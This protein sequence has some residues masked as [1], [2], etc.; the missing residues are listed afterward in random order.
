MGSLRGAHNCI[1]DLYPVVVEP[2]ETEIQLNDLLA[3]PKKKNGQ[4]NTGLTSADTNLKTPSVSNSAPSLTSNMS[5]HMDGIKALRTA[6]LLSSLPSF[7][8]ANKPPLNQSWGPSTS[9]QSAESSGP[10]SRSFMRKFHTAHLA[11]A[12]NSDTATA[13]RPGQH[14]SPVIDRLWKIRNAMEAPA[15][16]VDYAKPPQK[17]LIVKKPEDSMLSLEYPF[18]QDLALREKYRN[19]WDSMRVGRLL[20]DLDAIAGSVAFQHCSDNDPETRPLLLVT[21][22]VDRI[23]LARHI[24]MDADLAVTGKVTWVGRSSMEIQI[25]LDQPNASAEQPDSRPPLVANF[26]FVARDITTNK[27]AAINPLAPDTAEEKALFAEG[28]ARDAARKVRRKSGAGKDEALTKEQRDRMEAFL[29]AGRTMLELPA[30]ADRNSMLI[31]DTRLENAFLCQPQ[32]R[33]MH[34]RIFG[35]FLMRRAF[36]LAF[37]T[38]YVFCGT[39]PAF[40]E[41]HDIT[42][43]RPVDVGDL[44]RFKSCVLYTEQ[45][46]LVRPLIHVE[47][48]AYVTKPELRTSQVSNTFYFTFTVH[49]D[50]LK[51]HAT[52]VRRV[53][54]S[55]EEEAKRYMSRFDADHS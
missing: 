15:P 50:D 46:D 18:S 54:P 26:T 49:P 43:Q 14:H 40:L 52:V 41:M 13:T 45:S 25:R 19:P 53:L 5:P 9:S 24:R 21:A 39:R 10:S 1:W 42:F 47:V 11:P 35:G 29:A 38:C 22:S 33:N 8:D 48:V 51:S 28:E 27:A 6:F 55:T 32:Q 2:A 17:E 30:L 36:E 3:A 44:L 34:G 37:S 7:W 4:F 16:A 31:R 20:E 23:R 12:E